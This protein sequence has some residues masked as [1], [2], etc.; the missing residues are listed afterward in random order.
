[1]SNEDFAMMI[2]IPSRIRHVALGTALTVFVALP[3]V[4]DD[5]EIYRTDAIG[6]GVKPN[7]LFIIDTSG[8]MDSR[9]ETTTPQYNP[10]IN[11]PGSCQADRIYYSTDGEVPDC[12]GD[13]FPRTSMACVASSDALANNTGTGS[14]PEVGTRLA[15][16][17]REDEEDED[18]GMTWQRIEAQDSGAVECEADDGVHGPATPADPD[19]LWIN[20]GGSGWDSTTHNLWAGRDST[21]RFFTANYI[22]YFRSE[23]PGQESHSAADRARRGTNA[24]D[25]AR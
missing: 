19:L 11:Y 14:W 22:N 25:D 16:Q 5:T 12:G 18:A 2:R 23:N 13:S 4:A 21:Y 9:V 6:A 8:S 3:A 1:M 7:V 17:F 10:M 20:D 15:A 24:D